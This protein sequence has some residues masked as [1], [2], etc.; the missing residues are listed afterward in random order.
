M[1]LNLAF[2]TCF[3]GSVNNIAFKIPAVPSTK[4]KC[5]YYTNNYKMLETLKYTKWIGIFHDVP[6]NEDL[7]KSAMASKYVKACP[8][9]F[10]ELKDYSYL[11]YLDSKL[12]INVHLIETI[13]LDYFIHDNYALLLPEHWFIR[14][15]VWNEF[16]EAMRQP[17]YKLQAEKY[18]TYITTQ[19]S[20][21]LS[22]T[23]RHHC[24]TGLLIRNM[25]H[26]KIKDINSTWYQHIQ[27]CGI[28]CQI[29][30]FFVKQL[31]HECVYSLKETNK[32][33]IS[34]GL[35]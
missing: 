25:K 34:L 14:H 20:N 10:K 5:Y 35:S 12:E 16:N 29:S 23:T 33:L 22:R 2:Y 6:T 4:Y 27:E 17:R 19:I 30:F 3:Y 9:E 24:C 26:P 15:D 8:H 18:K 11:C 32:L 31:F 13:I 7:I 21:G 28:E 1:D